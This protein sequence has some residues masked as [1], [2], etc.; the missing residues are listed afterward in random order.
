MPDPTPTTEANVYQAIAVTQ[1]HQRRCDTVVK[2]IETL[3]RYRPAAVEYFEDA[4]L[5]A[6]TLCPEDE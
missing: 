1:A 3:L 2:A 4:M 6:P 5:N